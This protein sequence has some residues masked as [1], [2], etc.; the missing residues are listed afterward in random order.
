MFSIYP[1]GEEFT[2]GSTLA[3]ATE[4]EKVYRIINIDESDKNEF[5]ESLNLSEPGLNKL[6]REGYNALELITFF[7]S[8]PKESKAWTIKR[9]SLAPHAAGKIHTDFE[10][11][12]I[13]AETISYE[14]LNKIGNFSSA[15]DNGKV[16]SE[17]KE[18]QIRDGDV[19]NFRFNV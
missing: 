4:I 13:K 17:G 15:K 1:T 8:G 9:G 3:D 12:F 5:L 18:Y 19:V 7:T 11:G 10:K 2:Y 6:I 16:R 14:E